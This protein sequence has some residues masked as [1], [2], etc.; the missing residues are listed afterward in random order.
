MA[1]STSRWAEAMREVALR[2]GEMPSE[3]GFPAYLPTRLAEFYERSGRVVTL[4]KEGRVGSVSIA[5]SV[6]PPGGDFTEPVTSHTLRFIGAFWPLSPK[7]AYSRH[8][9]AIDW[10]MGF[11]RY[12]EVV[13]EWYGK[14][15]AQDWLQIREEAVRVL[16]REA[17]LQE[18]VRILGTE[19]LSEQEKHI[20]NTAYLIREGFLKQDS[21]NPTDVHTLPEKQYWLLR[22]MITFYRKG[23]EVINKGVP[24]G[25][26]RELDAVKR[27]PRLRMEVRNEDYQRLV[28]FEKNLV[29]TMEAL[30]KGTKATAT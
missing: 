21:F 30:A 13:S 17:E 19:A 27:I 22:T 8:Y 18:V 28:E 1:D 4:G 12:V 5:A 16:T 26:I 3:E 14:N 7:L 9:P 10:L 24:A 25:T 6:S 20:L 11:S 23:L 15:V 2:I 29:D